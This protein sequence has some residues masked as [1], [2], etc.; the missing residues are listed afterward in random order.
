METRKPRSFRLDDPKVV[1]AGS[2]EEEVSR[3]RGGIV[4]T[5]EPDFEEAPPTGPDIAPV[6]R[7]PWGVLFWSAL[8]GLASLAFGLSVTRLVDELFA[9]AQWLGWLGAALAGL[10]LLA[11]LVVAVR[12][13]AGLWRLARIEGLHARALAASAADDRDA[14]RSLVH[15][16]LALYGGEPSLARARAMVQGAS[17]D[18]VDGADLIDVAER[19]LL[20]PLDARARA[21]IGD[22]ARRVS[23]VTAVSP[24]A[25]VDVLFVAAETLRLTRRL[26]RLYGG[27]PGA[28][29]LL[30]LLR[31]ALGNLAVTGGMAASD[32]ILGE[33]V[34]HGV[35]ARISARLGEGV[36]NGILIAR[37]GL[38]A[39]TASRPLPFRVMPRPSVGDVA[40]GLFSR[41]KRRPPG[42][43]E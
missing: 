40:G 28:L 29:G 14:A 7:S 15:D 17:R 33:V 39:M 2:G 24:R 38:A 43:G 35:A 37:L 41:E 21:L 22:A 19:E 18:I 34:G 9:Y 16:L 42:D 3:P 8:G 5:P 13:V 10:A 31:H 12:E 27:R 36:L 25:L 23:L 20:G 30:R 32:S 1:L 4:V 26:G 6:R 11:L